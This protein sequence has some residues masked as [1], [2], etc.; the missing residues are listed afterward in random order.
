MPKDA[1]LEEGKRR[2]F[3]VCDSQLITSIGDTVANFSLL[4]FRS[5]ASWKREEEQTKELMH[6]VPVNLHLMLHFSFDFYSGEKKL[7][8]ARIVSRNF[9]VI[10]RTAKRLIDINFTYIESA[11]ISLSV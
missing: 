1:S 8:L 9:P 10:I 3:V 2:R 4:N 6:A 5:D 11:D 7:V